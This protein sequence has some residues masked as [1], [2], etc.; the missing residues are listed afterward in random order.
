MR[1]GRAAIVGLFLSC[2]RGQHL[3]PDDVPPWVPQRP[4]GQVDEVVARVGDVPIFASE[5]RSQMMAGAANPQIALD[6]LVQFHLLAEGAR[7]AGLWERSVLGPPPKEIWV[8]RLIENNLE[9]HLAKRD[10]PDGELRKVYEQFKDEFVHPRLVDV[11]LLAV[12]TGVRMKP[13]AQARSRQTAADLK[14][15]LE[16]R[17][18]RSKEDFLAIAEEP[19]WKDRK[20]QFTRLVQGADKPLSAKVGAQ[21]AKLNAPGDTTPMVED[22]T[23]FYVARYIGQFPAKDRSFEDARTELRDGYHTHWR[24]ERF[25]AFAREIS[26]RHEIRFLRGP[27]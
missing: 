7:A 6:E 21:I 9:A 1:A 11:A 19:V 18:N 2:S 16:T 23:G 26:G 20:V 12:Y 25:A 13:E 15:F 27:L 22:E 4:A 3:G 24:E 14:A 17:T 5:I 8:Q 10:I